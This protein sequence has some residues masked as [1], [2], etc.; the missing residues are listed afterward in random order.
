MPSLTIC[1]AMSHSLFFS[2]DPNSWPRNTVWPPTGV[3]SPPVAISW[4]PSSLLRILHPLLFF[5]LTLSSLSSDI[6]L[7]ARSSITILFTEL[8]FKLMRTIWSQKMRLYSLYNESCECVREKEGNLCT[9]WGFCACCSCHVGACLRVL[10]A[11]VN[12]SIS[13]VCVSF[14]NLIHISGLDSVGC[15][16]PVHIDEC[17]VCLCVGG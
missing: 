17:T 9:V 15:S 2:P 16:W 6:H 5:I 13:T 4:P 7:L 8:I 3:K 11:C 1:L 14:L 10:V 12:I